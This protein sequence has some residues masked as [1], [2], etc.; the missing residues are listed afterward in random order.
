MAGRQVSLLARLS[1]LTVRS[2][3]LPSSRLVVA[4]CFSDGGDDNNN[5][6]N[7]KDDPFGVHF[8]DGS[9]GLG[10]DKPPSYVRDR[11]TGKMTGEVI[12]ELSDAD[13]KLLTSLEND[14]IAKNRWVMDRLVREW[15]EER[16]A[17]GESVLQ[18]RVADRIRHRDAALNTFGRSGPATTTTQKGKDASGQETYHDESGF[19]QPLSPDE[20][21]SLSRYVKQQHGFQIDESTIPVQYGQQQQ[22]QEPDA[23]YS[24][25]NKKENADLEWLS[26]AGQ[27]EMDEN[28]AANDPF[29]DLM[30]SDL[31]PARLVNRRK[32]KPIPKELL[33]HNNLSLLR[34]YTTPGGQI[35]NR[36]QSRLGA[37]DQ[38]KVAKL[39]KRARALGLIPYVGQWKVENHGNIHENDIHKDKEWEAELKRRGL[40][41]KRT[42]T[43]NR[44]T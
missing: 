21:K 38:R 11:A 3:S 14:E 32:A 42:K 40:E 33:H 23:A 15:N 22:Q 20:F 7:N 43:R 28:A 41:I 16:D 1:L 19:S 34:R 30:P 25:N 26:V 24:R 31:N 4:R 17:T 2:P 8:Q 44:K 18:S 5:N 9:D 27:R 12:R 36:V 29:L 10:P 35:M 39:V 37:K 6:D 13:E